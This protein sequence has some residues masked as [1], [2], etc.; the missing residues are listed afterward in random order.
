L[1]NGSCWNLWKPVRR[2]WRYQHEIWLRE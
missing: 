2:S 1:T